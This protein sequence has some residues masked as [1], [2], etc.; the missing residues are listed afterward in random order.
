MKKHLLLCLVV[1]VAAGGIFA[2]AHGKQA[3]AQKAVTPAQPSA[4]AVPAAPAKESAREQKAE[5]PGPV[6]GQQADRLLRQMS[7]YLKAPSSLASMPI[8]YTMICFPP[9]RRSSLP[10]Q[11]MC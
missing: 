3:A 10:L 11:M 9:A 7:D 2:L 1:V 6:I 4:L 5:A 8:S